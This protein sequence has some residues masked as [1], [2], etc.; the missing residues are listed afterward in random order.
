MDLREPLVRS[1][2]NLDLVGRLV[3][4]RL[5]QDSYGPDG[6]VL[7]KEIGDYEK[8]VSTKSEGYNSSDPLDLGMTLW[9]AHWFAESDEWARE[10]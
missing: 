2:G 3:V 7:A 4:L 8:I 6:P 5:L 9:T 1:E 10:L